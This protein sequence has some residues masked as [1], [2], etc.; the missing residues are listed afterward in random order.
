MS[1]VVGLVF[2][3]ASSPQKRSRDIDKAVRALLAGG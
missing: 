3:P 2:E 1:D